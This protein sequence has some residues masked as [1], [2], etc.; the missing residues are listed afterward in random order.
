M[1]NFLKFFIIKIL[2]NQ[3]LTFINKEYKH[4]ILDKIRKYLD[5]LNNIK[6]ILNNRIIKEKR[7]IFENKNEIKEILKITLEEE[8]Y[9]KI[10]KK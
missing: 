1:S 9:S 10:C 4:E 8:Q 6:N 2:L 5:T 3:K 7:N